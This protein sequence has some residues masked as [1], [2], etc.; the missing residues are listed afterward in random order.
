VA[1]RPSS[2]AVSLGDHLR[3]AVVIAMAVR[4]DHVADLCRIQ[5]QQAHADDT[6]VESQSLT[7][8]AAMSAS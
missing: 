6:N 8:A 4:D 2:G 5:P 7:P 3:T 1:W